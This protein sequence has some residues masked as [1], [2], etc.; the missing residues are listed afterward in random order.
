MTQYDHIYISP[1]LDDVVLSCGGTVSQ[2]TAAGET[3]L[4]ITA[5]AGDPAPG[6]SL[7][8]FAQQLHTR[9]DTPEDAAATRR[10]EDLAALQLLG[11]AGEHWSY[12]DCIYRQTPAGDFSYDT[13]ESLWGD[14]HPAEESLVCEI[15]QRI[16]ALPLARAG[17]FYVPL[18]V[19]DHVDHSIIHAAAI[20]CG[21]PVV[22]Y[23]DFPYSRDPDTILR[24]L[25]SGRWKSYRTILTEKALELKITAIGCY[26]S[27]LSTFWENREAM[28]ADI[29][30]S[31]RRVGIGRP[32]ERFWH[33]EL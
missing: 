28:E 1:H 30:E 7:S 16:L 24:K 23:E 9:W 4:V 33:Q 20:Q 11:A 10:Q 27:Q 18:G 26:R 21:R 13:E 29:R 15:V 6:S 31:S 2:Q 25:T 3:V 22:F 19:G 14:I 32:A 8:P 12:A 17:A 5:F